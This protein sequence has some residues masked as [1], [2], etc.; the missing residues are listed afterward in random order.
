MHTLSNN[1]HNTR[2][3]IP[4]YTHIIQ[5]QYENTLSHSSPCQHSIRKHRHQ[6][7]PT[8]HGNTS[9]VIFAIIKVWI[10]GKCLNVNKGEH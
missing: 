5:I 2:A 8:G 7:F 3:Q 9:K 10:K 6:S 1:T 4:T